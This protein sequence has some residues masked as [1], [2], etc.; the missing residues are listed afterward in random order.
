MLR[1]RDRYMYNVG[2]HTCGFR[3][4]LYMSCTAIPRFSIA[5]ISKKWC[6]AQFCLKKFLPREGEEGRCEEAR[7]KSRIGWK[8]IFSYLSFRIPPIIYLL[9]WR[10]FFKRVIIFHCLLMWFKFTI[11]TNRTKFLIISFYEI[12]YMNRILSLY[13]II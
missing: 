2:F 12:N 1:A 5:C 6:D 3:I 4:V 8:I 13:F 11:T 10:W 7:E 9:C